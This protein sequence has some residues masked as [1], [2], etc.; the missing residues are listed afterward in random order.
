MPSSQFLLLAISAGGD[1]LS[2]LETWPV[3]RIMVDYGEELPGGDSGGPDG[4]F[5]GRILSLRQSKAQR[6]FSWKEAR[7][8][9]SEAGEL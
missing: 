7:K 6:R 8:D 5:E 9:C 4:T 3:R 1:G 2:S